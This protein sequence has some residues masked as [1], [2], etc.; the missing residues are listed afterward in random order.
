MDGSGDYELP[1]P[2]SSDISL[3]V[4]FRPSLYSRVPHPDSSVENQVLAA[5]TRAFANNATLFNASKFR[6]ARCT[7]DG[8]SLTLHLG[9]T[10][11]A[12]FQGTH[13][14]AD[15]LAVFGEQGLARPFGNAVIVETCDGFVPLLKRSLNS[16][17]GG[18]HIVTPGGYPEPSEVGLYSDGGGGGCANDMDDNVARE[19]WYAA[20]R[21]VLEELFVPEVALASTSEMRCL[22]VVSRKR[23]AKALLALW[24]GVGLTADEVRQAYENGNS[25]C[26]ESTALEFVAIGQLET[27]LADCRVGSGRIMPDHLGAVDLAVCYYRWRSQIEIGSR[28]E[29]CIAFLRKKYLSSVS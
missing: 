9:L 15:A 3:R 12:E 29:G 22:G 11:Y 1:C 16:G 23:D 5:A 24:A 7:V 19:L 26:A 20:R 6:F 27:V 14:G 18:G 10:D 25:G 13:A 4:L 28:D 17:E 8:R 21:E 2:F